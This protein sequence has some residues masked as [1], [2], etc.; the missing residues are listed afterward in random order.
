LTAPVA[1]SARIEAVAT[2]D[3]SGRMCQAEMNASCTTREH[4]PSAG[5]RT[6]PI[7]R[8]RVDR[9]LPR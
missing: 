9:T 6:D 7:G 2:E 5:E 3:P 4:A 8:Y 1:S